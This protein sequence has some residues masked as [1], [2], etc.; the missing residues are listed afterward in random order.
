MVKTVQIE[1]WVV[2]IQY[3]E[4]RM[5]FELNDFRC[6][7]EECHNFV[8]ASAGIEPVVLKFAEKLG[9][10]LSKPSQLNSHRLDGN[11]VMYTGQYHIVGEIIEGDVNGWD[12]VVGQHCFSLTNEFTH[13]PVVMLEPIIEISF[14]VVLPWV[15]SSVK[16][17]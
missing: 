10:D 11:L 12:L 5:A 17:V 3:E 13:I 6:R 4:T 9:I 15:L 8:K 7:S 14:E 2:A 1:Q 16:S